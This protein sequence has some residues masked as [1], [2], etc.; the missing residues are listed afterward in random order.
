[1]NKTRR[2]L[3]LPHPLPFP[4]PQFPI[5]FGIGGHRGAIEFADATADSPRPLLTRLTRLGAA[6]SHQT[7]IRSMQITAHTFM[8]TRLLSPADH[9]RERKERRRRGD[10]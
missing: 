10:A 2:S 5:P 3:L 6:G 8:Q 9:I 4:R 7:Q 1:M